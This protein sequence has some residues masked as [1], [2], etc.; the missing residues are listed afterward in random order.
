MS[1]LLED[2][3]ERILGRYES[4]NVIAI[5]MIVLLLRVYIKI[6]FLECSHC[7]DAVFKDRRKLGIPKKCRVCNAKFK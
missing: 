2:E 4:L 3:I 5:S 6:K 1:V 7:G